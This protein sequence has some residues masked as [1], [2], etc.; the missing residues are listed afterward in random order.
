MRNPIISLAPFFYGRVL[1]KYNGPIAHLSE[2]RVTI[3]QKNYAQAY[4][5]LVESCT[6]NQANNKIPKIYDA[7]QGCGTHSSMQVARYKAISEALERW[8]FYECSS[9]AKNRALYGFDLDSSTNGMAAYPSIEH[10][11]ARNAAYLEAVERYSLVM[12]WGAK[13]QVIRHDSSQDLFDVYEIISFDPKVKIALLHYL[14]PESGFHVYGFAAASNF[15]KAK[16]HAAI[17]MHRNLVAMRRL[18]DSF[19]ISSDA[20][21]CGIIDFQKNHD[22]SLN[23]KRVLFFASNSGYKKWSDRL[24]ESLKMSGVDVSSLSPKIVYDGPIAGPWSRF[25]KVWRVCFAHEMYL[26]KDVDVFLF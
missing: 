20:K 2:H 1:A 15:S 21:D 17:E 9:D 4:A 18:T 26:S 3:W 23:E 13:L 11:S 14:D 6:S 19:K 10:K 5:T 12:W 16:S 7:V 22:L 25:A 8:A 24:N